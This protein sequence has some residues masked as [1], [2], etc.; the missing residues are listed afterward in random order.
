M[1][2]VDV[3]LRKTGTERWEFSL[4]N[5]LTG[6]AT[7]LFGKILKACQNGTATG[8]WGGS[9][10][11]VSMLGKDLRPLLDGITLH[12]G[13]RRPGD[14]E[15]LDAFRDALDDNTEYSIDCIEV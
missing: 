11:E 10:A 9:H 7:G 2:T 1:T 12:G 13:Y 6:P 15:R 3:Y 5:G 4:H 8:P 14:T